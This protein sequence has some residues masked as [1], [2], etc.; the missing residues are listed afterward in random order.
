MKT[1][2][3]Y[4]HGP[5]LMSFLKVVRTLCNSSLDIGLNILSFSSLVSHLG[6]KEI[7]FKISTILA[8]IDS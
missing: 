1:K 7:T 4:Q 3:I 6:K 8:P 2:P 5:E